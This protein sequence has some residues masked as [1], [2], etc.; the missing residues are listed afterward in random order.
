MQIDDSFLLEEITGQIIS[1]GAV[2]IR[3]VDSG[4]NPFVYS[5]GNRGPGYVM[6]KGLVGQPKT[7]NFLTRKLAEKI[8][9]HYGPHFEFV[10]GNATGGMV[11][12]WQFR[13]DLEDVLGLEKGTIPY[14][15]LRGTRKEGGHGELIT[16]NANNP[17][18]KK[19]MPALV[20]EELVN[21]ATTTTNAA[22]EFRAAGYPVSH[23]ACILFYDNPEARR[24]LK[25][26]EVTQLYL[27]TLPELLDVAEANK[28][29]SS[30]AV[31]S[32]RESLRDPLGWQLSRNMVIPK[33]SAKKA[34]EQGIHMRELQAEEALKL[35][36]PEAYLKN[37]FVYW[38]KQT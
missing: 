27:I 3:D 8:S 1:S 26:N 21:Y 30:T 29:L 28:L 5:S 13:S 2:E 11:P 4:Q 18:I 33:E 10:E 14:T 6:I 22:K 34:L 9:S 12:A 20:F 37:G 24:L 32:Y 19:G 23:G 25:E 15:Y 17:L 35:G 38:A 36:A 7:L 31:N 16:G